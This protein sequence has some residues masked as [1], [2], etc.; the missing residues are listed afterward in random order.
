LQV[1]SS[2]T[3]AAVGGELFA[4]EH[5]VTIEDPGF[6]HRFAGHAKTKDVALAADEHAVDVNGVLG[7]LDGLAE[8]TCCDAA[9]DGNFDEAVV[10]GRRAAAGLAIGGLHQT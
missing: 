10:G 3:L 9:H 5:E 8:G 2:P 1:A 4:H 7:V 6:D